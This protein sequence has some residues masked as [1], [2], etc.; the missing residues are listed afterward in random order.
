MMMERKGTSEMLVAAHESMVLLQQEMLAFGEIL[1]EEARVNGMFHKEL[2]GFAR[3]LDVLDTVCIQ[4]RLKHESTSVSDGPEPMGLGG[5]LE[6]AQEHEWTMVGIGA[7]GTLDEQRS[8]G[9]PENAEFAADANDPDSPGSRRP[10]SLSAS[11]VSTT[12]TRILAPRT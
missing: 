12:D 7:D 4:M 5:D 3:A 6:E 9:R 11:T 10:S 1:R 2:D 8:A